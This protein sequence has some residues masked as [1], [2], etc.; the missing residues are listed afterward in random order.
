MYRMFCD[1]KRLKDDYKSMRATSSKN[2]QYS[3]PLGIGRWRKSI[4][5]VLLNGSNKEYGMRV[6]MKV[7]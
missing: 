3:V 5:I 6:M 4:N 7:K 2:L 1:Q